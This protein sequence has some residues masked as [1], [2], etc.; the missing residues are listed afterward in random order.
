VN[1]KQ[2]NSKDNA[3]TQNLTPEV[4]GLSGYQ[5]NVLKKTMAKARKAFNEK[6][7]ELSEDSCRQCIDIY[8][9]YAAPFAVLGR[10]AYSFQKFELAATYF[11][12]SLDILPEVPGRLLFYSI[13]LSDL[14]RQE[15]AL[16]AIDKCL[17]INP[18]LIHA[19]SSRAK[20]LESLGR[21]DEAIE[22]YEM[23]MVDAP[24]YS[25]PFYNFSFLHKFVKGDK[26]SKTFEKLA[27]NIGSIGSD[28]GLVDAHFALG[29]YYEDIGEHKT[30]FQ[31]YL[32][33][34]EIMSNGV[35]YKIETDF[36][37]MDEC[38]VRFPKGGAWLNKTE[39]GCKTDVPVFIVGMPRSGTTLI[40]QILASH[41]VIHGA[42]ELTLLRKHVDECIVSPFG[43][44]N[45]TPLDLTN[46]KQFRKPLSQSANE[47]AEE[48]I[49]KK[50]GAK[51]IVDKMPHNFLL[52]GYKHLF[53]PNAKVIH[54]KRNPID[55]CLS[56]FCIQFSGKFP[57][58]TDLTNLG[59]YYV[60]Y[61]QLM[62]HWKEVLPDQIL[63]V[64]YENVIDNVE[65][66]ARRIVDF[67]GLEWEEECLQFFKHKRSVNTASF[68]QVRQPIYKSSV[69]RHERYGDFL[70]PLIEAL[71]PVL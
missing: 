18:N 43:D 70:N 42:G 1:G 35:E 68:V 38:K 8:P 21:L 12:K 39:S 54:C 19:L 20:A 58:A 13:V 6:K 55:T 67:L 49:A 3:A 27:E 9:H 65:F 60:A 44:T 23:L 31:H 63:E 41:S 2:S 34:N 28:N 32:T 61:A 66:Q 22:V 52:L 10:I 62:E 50:P 29:K 48:I 46:S 37:L 16:D 15:E 56:N 17:N 7:Y 71:Q 36:A 59:K 40:E 25:M 51:H 57:F 47:L 33:A 26:Y 14:N 4:T 5:L 53:L 11:K 30:G 64:E 69:G 45:V 24:L